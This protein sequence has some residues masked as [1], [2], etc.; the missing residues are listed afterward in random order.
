MISFRPVI[1]EKTDQVANCDHI[2]EL[3]NS[4]SLPYAFT[5]YGTIMGASVLNTERVLEVSVL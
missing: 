2:S 1:L 4:K 5:E 3:K